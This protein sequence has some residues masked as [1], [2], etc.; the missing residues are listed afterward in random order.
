VFQ[1]LGQSVRL[2]GLVFR[3]IVDLFNPTTFA[4]SV[5]GVRGPV[6]ISVMAAEAAAAGPLSYAGLIAMLSLSLGVMN[7]LPLPP[8]DGG[9][10]VLEIAERI[11][12]K[13]ISRSVSLGLSA[14]GAV[15]LFSL[16]GYI[17][18]ADIARLA[19]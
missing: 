2:T 12:G 16:I 19:Q 10:I 5:Q 9:K 1:S 15:L 3:A 13:P 4:R 17:M 14:A 7:I 11:I 6:G 18:Y 8:L